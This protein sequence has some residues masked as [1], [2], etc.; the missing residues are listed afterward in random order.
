MDTF[1]FLSVLS[2]NFRGEVGGIRGQHIKGY[3]VI[4]IKVCYIFAL[5]YNA[6]ALWRNVLSSISYRSEHRRCY[7]FL[8]LSL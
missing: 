4:A 5:L 8:Q 1:N 3:T 6:S 2:V 7:G